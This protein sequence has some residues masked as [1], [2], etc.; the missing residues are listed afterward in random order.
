MD[1][2]CTLPPCTIE[3][4]KNNDDSLQLNGDSPYL[5][6]ILV[7]LPSSPHHQQCVDTPGANDNSHNYGVV[8]DA[9]E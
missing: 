1:D 7:V 3:G 9:E 5:H 6:Q 4:R 2:K 8:E